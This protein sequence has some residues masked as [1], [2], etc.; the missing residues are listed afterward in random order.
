MDLAD[1]DETQGGHA[2]RVMA[3]Y[4]T[5]FGRAGGQGA[6]ELAALRLLGFFDRPAAAGCLAAL[7]QAPP[8]A[9]L[10]EPLFVGSKRFLGLGTK[11][12]PMTETDW[13]LTLSRLSDGGLIEPPPADRTGREAP[14]IDAHP[15]VREYLGK[16]LHEAHPDAWREG[17]R[18]L[19]EYLKAGVPERPDGMAG[20]QP[21][22]QA[23]AHGC[24]AGLQ[25]QAC[26]EVYHERIGQRTNLAN[27]LQ[28]QGE[29]G[30]A[31]GCF[32]EAETMQTE[33]QPQYPQIYSLPGYRYCDLLLAGPE[34]TTWRAL[35]ALW[36]RLQPRR[37]VAATGE[38]QS[39]PQPAPTGPRHQVAGQGAASR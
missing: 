20:L 8:M 38:A 21:L 36:E 3:A 32:R 2:F 26:E 34:R 37:E 17:H 13:N 14:A 6:R 4:E 22:Y 7:R 33:H 1:A 23:V 16:R 35:R 12:T 31:L 30:P 39:R 24:L 28:Q 15:L 10:T 18:R 5:C 9:G 11:Y 29:R 27:A 25:Q 19:Y